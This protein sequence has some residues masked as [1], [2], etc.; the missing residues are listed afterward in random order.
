MTDYGAHVQRIEADI[1]A[2][3]REAEK[4]SGPHSTTT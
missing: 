4:S 3:R 2:L 1:Q